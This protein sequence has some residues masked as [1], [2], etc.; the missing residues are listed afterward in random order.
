MVCRIGEKLP[1]MVQVNT[2]GETNKNGLGEDFSMFNF[3]QY[4]QL[5]IV[6]YPLLK[7]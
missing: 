1:V 2:S 5:N 7:G 4:L 3:L 6:Y